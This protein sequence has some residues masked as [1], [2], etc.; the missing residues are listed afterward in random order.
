MSIEDDKLKF[1]NSMAATQ[2][3]E[4]K[5]DDY[6]MRKFRANLFMDDDSRLEYL[7]SER[8]PNDPMGALRYRVKDNGNIEYR[9]A[10]GQWI[11]EFPKLRD[12]GFFQNRVVPNIMPAAN[13]T[14]DIGGAMWGAKKGFDA[15][16]KLP[17]PHPVAKAFAVA[18]TTALG[19]A[20]GAFMTGAP[21]RAGRMSMI[22][23][24]YSLPPDEVAKQ[25]NDLGWSVG[26]SALP[27]GTG[28]PQTYKFLNKFNG[29]EDALQY[30]MSLKGNTDQ[31]MKE[32]VELGIPLTRAE[33]DLA[34]KKARQIQYYISRQPTV[35]KMD[36]FYDSRASIIRETVDAFADRVGSGKGGDI[37]T[38]IK[39]ASEWTLNE[40]MSRRKIRA[41][42][43]YD[44]LKETPGGIKISDDLLGKVIQQIDDEIAGVVRNADGKI[45]NNLDISESTVKNLEKF[46]KMFYTKDGD[47]VTDLMSLDQRRTSEMKELFLKLQDKGTGDAGKI[48]SVM[49]DLTAVMDDTMPNYKLARRVYD[50]NKPALQVIERN[51]LAKIAKLGTDKQTA[52]ALKN[53]FDPNVSVKSLRNAKRILKTVDPDTFKDV[54]KEFI[55]QTLDKFSNQSFEQGLPAF[56]KY[57]AK[58]NTM[59]MMETMLEPKEFEHWKK[60]V[61][62]MG[63]AFSIHRG[64]SP[65]QPLQVFDEQVAQ[66]SKSG[67]VKAT[68][69]LIS[70]VN[71][72]PRMVQARFGE[73]IN[74]KI[75]IRQKEA[76]QEKMADLLLDDGATKI[77]DDMFYFFDSNKYG[78]GQGIIRGGAEAKEVI[79]R[80]DAPYGGDL[81]TSFEETSPYRNETDNLQGAMQNFEQ[82]MPQI[83]QPLFEESSLTPM[84][85][86]SPT[87]LPNEKDREI[88]LRNSGIA[89]LV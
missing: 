40:L 34:N 6:M 66:W 44:I 4:Q 49:Q 54:K 41:G 64:G 80:Q 78:A 13:F 20:G 50:P 69:G 21:A 12:Y 87:L 63:K 16:L 15:G 81:P 37:N 68:Q 82:S 30:L 35:F 39:E 65:T 89:R 23:S 84:E 38:R 55:L 75:A 33:V 70:L 48:W 19:G 59:K 77:F 74:R 10:T 7:A 24:F 26:F 52:T 3:A 88:A 86:L 67:G 29:K 60:M 79:S 53:L 5:N 56:Q 85:A 8:F 47:L 2:Y 62:A 28:T 71:F 22:N 9:D 72:I 1:A 27:F 73:N 18:G 51:A 46:K 57:M 83:D 11:R 14:A 17:I 76:Y 45:I 61:G 25:W 58:S 32:S 36:D 43:I 42:K 31:M